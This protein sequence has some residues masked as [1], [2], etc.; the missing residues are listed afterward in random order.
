MSS[1][2]RNLTA[3]QVDLIAWR[4]AAYACGGGSGGVGNCPGHVGVV[5][6]LQGLIVNKRYG[7]A[8]FTGYTARDSLIGR[9]SELD[10]LRSGRHVPIDDE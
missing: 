8:Y 5:L 3:W 2:R 9:P 1:N 4:K 7:D 10:S 6:Y